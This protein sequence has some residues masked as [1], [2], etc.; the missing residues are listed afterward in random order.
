MADDKRVPDFQL[1]VDGAAADPELKGSVIGVRV[2]DDMDKS[3]RF[4]LH[5]SDIDRKWTKQDKFKPGTAIEIK[6]GFIGA[7]KSVCKGEVSNLEI[8]LTPDG[9]TRL[10]IA[11]VDKGHSFDKGTV[12]KT[13]K[14]VKDSDLASQIAQRHGLT[15]DADD[16]VVVHDY[17][18]QNNLSDYDFL[19]QRAALAG[20]RM[21]VDDKKLLFKKPKL[22]DPPSATLTWKENIGRFIQE[23]NTF[24]QV[25]KI[26]TTGWDPAKMEQITGPAKKGDEY[27]Q[28]GGTTYHNRCI[29]LAAGVPSYAPIDTKYDARK[30]IVSTNV[31][32][33]S[34]T[35]GSCSNSCAGTSPEKRSSTW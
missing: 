16:S 10:V 27:G 30:I 23:V 18:I 3:S 6:L 2:T 21:Y 25:S 24:D 9:P 5:L 31:A 7:L 32:E 28:Q 35:P 17:V 12:T 14:D 34:L 1:M 13:Y 19:M 33:T 8:V 22:G 29:L 20:Y 15:A 11:G 26:T 4:W